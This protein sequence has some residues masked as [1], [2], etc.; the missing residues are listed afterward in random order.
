MTCWTE[1]TSNQH[2]V[3]VTDMAYQTLYKRQ[4]QRTRGKHDL[5][6][7][8]LTQLTLRYSPLGV[9]PAQTDRVVQTV[10]SIADVLSR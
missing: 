3:Q 7:T 8:R 10:C 6:Q 9:S 5:V 1:Y 2:D 4:T